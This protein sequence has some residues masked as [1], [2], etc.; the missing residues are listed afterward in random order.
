MIDEILL[1]DPS[2]SDIPKNKLLFLQKLFFESKEKKQNELL[3]FFLSL[4]KVSKEENI[5]F[6]DNEIERIIKVI[7]ENSSEQD[8]AKINYVLQKYKQND[9]NK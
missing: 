1:N 5:T 9:S 8:V 3:P 6:N 7:K 4:V 2:L